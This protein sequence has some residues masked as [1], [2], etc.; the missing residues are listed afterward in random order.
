[1][2]LAP[3]ARVA[4]D[5]HAYPREHRVEGDQQTDRCERDERL[6]VDAAATESADCILECGC[7]YDREQDRGHQ[8]DDQLARCPNR[9][10]QTAP[11]EC[12]K[13]CGGSIHAATSSWVSSR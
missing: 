4:I 6:V 10:A 11:R 13:C 8:R 5:D 12:A 1:E 7:D 2:Q 9:Q 3:R